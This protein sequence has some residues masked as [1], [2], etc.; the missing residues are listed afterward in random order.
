MPGRL[1]ADVLRW[2]NLGGDLAAGVDRELFCPDEERADDEHGDHDA[3]GAG[4]QQEAAAF[5]V[6][7]QHADGG[8]E[9]VDEGERD[10]APV[11]LQVTQTA[12]QQDAGVVEDDRVDAGCGVAGEDG[13]GQDEG[14]DVLSAEKRLFDRVAG[15][16]P[17]DG[18]F[19]GLFHLAQFVGG[20]L[21]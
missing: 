13:A 16:L 6:D 4:N 10:V 20:L 14:D 2:T 1:D 12:L 18:D 3:G 8:H 15:G 19:G 21:L 7:E 11:G 5:A 17:G 9:E